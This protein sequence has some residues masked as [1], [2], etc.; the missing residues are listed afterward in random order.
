MNELSK[1]LMING[2]WLSAFSL[3]IGF[4]LILGMGFS[5]PLPIADTTNILIKNDTETI[6]GTTGQI[7]DIVNQIRIDTGGTEYLPHDNAT[8]YARMLDANSRPINI[9]ACNSTVFLPNK[10]KLLNN[11]AL[12]FLEK[13]IYFMDFVV[14]SD[15][16]VYIT[17]FDCMFPSTTFDVNKTL[18]ITLSNPNPV[19]FEDFAFDNSNNLTINSASLV[20]NY[21]QSA[22]AQF[23][24]FFSNFQVFTSTMGADGASTVS[25]FQSNFTQSENQEFNFQLISA[26]G[27]AEI[28]SIRLTVNYTANEPQQTVRG[29]DE[30][31]VR[32][33]LDKIPIQ[34]AI[35]SAEYNRLS[36]HNLCISNSTL[37]HNITIKIGDDPQLPIIATEPCEFGCDLENNRCNPSPFD[38]LIWYVIG[39]IVGFVILLVIVLKLIK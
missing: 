1:A 12:T 39:G 21:D 14:P 6:K 16:G 10:T 8:I 28:H 5:A 38:A 7:F 36:N 35:I 15:T 34:T 27:T 2:S 18:G 11:V 19:F 33:D 13:G 9:G 23:R 31:H 3:I 29:Q 32:T 30:I 17:T 20:F 25:L 22:T 26:T 37:Q 4:P 24:L